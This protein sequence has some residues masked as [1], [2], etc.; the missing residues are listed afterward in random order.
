MESALQI[1]RTRIGR[2]IRAARKHAGLSHDRLAVRVG[3]SRQH[4][5]RLEK[6]VHMPRPELLAA[7]ARETGRPEEFFTGDDDD[8][9]S[10]LATDLHRLVRRYVREEIT[11]GVKR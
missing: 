2:K 7:I 1:H 4:L 6:G 8:E 9:E 10:A 3:T 5:I 11:R